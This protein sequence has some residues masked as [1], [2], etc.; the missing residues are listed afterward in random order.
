MGFQANVLKVMIASPGDVAVERNMITEELFRWNNA[1]AVSRGLMLHPVRWET[2][3][4]PEMGAHPQKIINERLL[5]D[6]DIVVG[7]FG[8]RIGTA[9]PDYVSGSV[10]EIKRHVAAGKLAML[11]F[12]HVA[13]DPNSIDQV[14]WAALK[15]FKEECKAGGLYAEYG[16]HE[17]LRA[18]F[19]QHL[20]I[21]LNRPQYLWLARPDEVVEPQEPELTG[22]EMRLLIAGA[23]DRNG[24]VSTGST[25]GGFF[26][27]ANN[28]SFV[29][30]YPRSEASW[31][32]V[33]K[34]LSTIGYLE[35]EGDGLYKV[36]D[37][38]LAACDGVVMDGSVPP[39]DCG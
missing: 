6:A 19:G 21:A 5:L 26:V 15:Q 12:S 18:D 10:E 39:R 37:G 11:Y 22:N 30:D 38:A 3:S 25:I 9:T 23:C 1:N 14:Q 7:V 28:T 27:D 2:H 16:T 13:V 33:L 8:R 31:K 34:R 24:I 32:Q 20:A 36:T 35:R 17:Q 29:E 4:S